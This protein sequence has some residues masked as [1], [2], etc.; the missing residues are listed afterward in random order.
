V[1]GFSKFVRAV[2]LVA[3]LALAG[4]ARAPTMRGLLSERY[5]GYDQI[6][7]TATALA[8][9][10]SFDYL[11]GNVMALALAEPRRLTQSA[12]WNNV[13]IFCP[14]NVPLSAL[15]PLRLKSTTIVYDVD[16]SLRRALALSKLKTS[17]QLEHNEVEFL[18]RV[19]ITIDSPRIYSLRMDGPRPRYVAACTDALAS[20]PDLYRLRSVLVGTV[21]IDFVFKDN[22]GVFAR[23]NLLNKVSGSIGAGVVR[24]ES[25]SIVSENVVFGAAVRPVKLRPPNS[26]PLLVSMSGVN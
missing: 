17:L 16:F 18:R 6:L 2:S 13:G 21:A 10:P 9:E 22:V 23:L 14:T 3:L 26:K 5:P 11:P 24:G 1:N 19:S 7:P 4:C 12:L 15:R 20:R 25:Y 8:D